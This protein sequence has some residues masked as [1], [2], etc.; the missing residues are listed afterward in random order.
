MGFNVKHGSIGTVTKLAE[1]SGKAQFGQKQQALA[2]DIAMQ[3]QGQK[4][5]AEMAEFNMMM[6]MESQKA[7]MQWEFQKIQMRQQNDF[8]MSET[9]RMQAIEEEHR[10]QMQK[11]AEF[12]AAIRAI[13][14]AEILSPAEKETMK[15][16]TSM[17]FNVGPYAPQIPEK[18][19]GM[20]QA[21]QEMKMQRG[22]ED[23]LMYYQ[24]IIN[25]F[26]DSKDMNWIP[27]SGGRGENNYVRK[28]A[29]GEW[30]PATEQ[31]ILTLD[32]AQKRAGQLLNQLRY[33]GGMPTGAASGAGMP[34]PEL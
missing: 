16:N 1:L 25:S 27:F 26:S 11:Q 34:H 19:D 30:Q 7:Q 9:L 17:K 15:T 3:L 31:D 22:L 4:Q 23:D 28:D 14:N 12:E 2:L 33:A 24:D 13:D 6:Q 21:A 8:T 20:K 18:M 32:Y 29:D 10:K 5:Q